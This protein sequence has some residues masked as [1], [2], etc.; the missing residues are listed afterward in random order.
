MVIAG[1]AGS[2]QLVSKLLN[3]L[4]AEFKLPI[5]LCMH[6]LKNVS[7]GFDDALN[8]RS[9]IPVHEPLDKEVIKAKRIYLAPAN[10]HLLAEVGNT[11]SLSVDDVYH[12]SRP[13]ID[14]TLESFS[15]VHREKILGIILSGAN[16]DGALGMLRCKERG[17]YTIV[18][19]PSEAAVRT[20]VSSTLQLFK[21]DKILTIDGII[22]FLNGL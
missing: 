11:I 19:E 9:V 17:G 2:F 22:A 7:S 4:N 21:P 20:M 12:Y 5:I 13:S 6:R 14:L 10:Y 16:A 15:F 8:I 3:E 18:Q 1:S